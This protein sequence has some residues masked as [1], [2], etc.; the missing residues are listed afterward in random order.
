[1]ISLV[2]IC[3][4]PGVSLHSRSEAESAAIIHRVNLRE[5]SRVLPQPIQDLSLTLFHI[6]IPYHY[7]T[8]LI[9]LK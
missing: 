8:L 7:Q 3:V 5:V 6:I 1:M 9:E 4:Q 2:R